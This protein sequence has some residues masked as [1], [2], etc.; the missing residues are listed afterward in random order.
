LLD[1]ECFFNACAFQYLGYDIV[2]EIMSIK[3]DKC[4]PYYSQ[5]LEYDVNAVQ[6]PIEYS[7]QISEQN[8]TAYPTPLMTTSSSSV[9]FGNLPA[10]DSDIFVSVGAQNVFGVQPPGLPAESAISKFYMN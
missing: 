8:I 10:N 1:Q 2:T 4:F 3:E 9:L 7:V 5:L 6:A